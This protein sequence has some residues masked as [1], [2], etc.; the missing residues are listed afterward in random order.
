MTGCFKLLGLPANATRAQVKA[1]WRD[2][3]KV[4]HPDHGGLPEKFRDLHDA[5]QEAMRRVGDRIC[6]PCK[7]SGRIDMHT[8]FYSV[9]MSC[10]ECNGTGKPKEV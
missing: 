5:Y 8:G 3:A 4:H 10:V 1:A 9:R 2:L 6:G 7:G